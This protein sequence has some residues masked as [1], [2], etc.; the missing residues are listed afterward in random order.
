MF[1]KKLHNKILVFA[2]TSIFCFSFAFTGMAQST[3]TDSENQV[4]TQTSSKSKISDIDEETQEL[5]RTQ[6]W[7]I[8]KRFQTAMNRL[9]NITDRIASRNK[10]MEE[11]GMLST[12]KSEAVTK[13]VTKAR[14]EISSAG[15]NII[16]AAAEI[17]Q[18]L[19]G[20]PPLKA[21]DNFKDY[22]QK[23]KSNIRNAKEQ[24]LK[25][26]EIMKSAQ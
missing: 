20:T 17:K 24:L 22:T 3:T 15:D 2:V 5:I 23:S 16:L 8:V 6:V 4:A 12:Q 18:A 26:L 7:K 9:A 13:K 1:N 19:S 11:Q 14:K 10:K 21:Y 25:G